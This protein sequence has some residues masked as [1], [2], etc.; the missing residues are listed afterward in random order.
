MEL[1]QHP[2]SAAFPAMSAD[3]FAALMEDIEANGQREPV[4]VFDGMVLDGWHRYRAC[5]ELGVKPHTMTFPADGDPVALVKT[6][7]LHRRHMTE[8]QRA[9]AVI[10]CSAWA[11]PHRLKNKQTPVS[12]SSPKTN[13]E[14]A[15][16]ARVSVGTIKNAKAGHQAG[17]GE[18]MK[19]GAITAREAASVARGKPQT[20]SKKQKRELPSA[21]PPSAPDMTEAR[22]TITEL[23]QENEA[24]RDRLAVEAMQV[25][26]DEKTQ[27]AETI[28]ELRALVKTLEAENASLKVSRDTYMH[29][30]GELKKQ[31]MAQQRELKKLRAAA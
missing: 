21:P 2:L 31:C 20:E 19:D 24:L 23:A 29:E 6:A 17:L 14:M 10:A 16:E 13:A 26:E 5:T 4:I 8:T 22:D 25:S 9:E 7:N 12:T 18:A 1:K 11:P 27:A 3:D 30:N 15:A 28:R